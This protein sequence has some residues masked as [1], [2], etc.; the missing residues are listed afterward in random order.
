MISQS[1]LSIPTNE[2]EAIQNHLVDNQKFYTK[3][4]EKSQTATQYALLILGAGT[5][6][7]ALYLG[8][9]LIP[10]IVAA[11]IQLALRK[12]GLRTPKK[13]I[14]ASVNIL[15]SYVYGSFSMW[16]RINGIFYGIFLVPAGVSFL[17]YN[18]FRKKHWHLERLK[19]NIKRYKT[20][21]EVLMPT[22]LRLELE[23]IAEKLRQKKA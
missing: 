7:N 11:P 22:P 19:E 4:E 23:K 3:W 2:I 21:Q 9:P 15:G 17:S 10:F 14:F 8:S 20:N 5:A 13:P 12:I 16:K 6:L 1:R 18:Y